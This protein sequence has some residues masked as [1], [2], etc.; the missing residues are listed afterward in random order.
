[1][2]LAG[3]TAVITGGAGGIGRAA[4]RLFAE[5][6]ASVLIAD[7]SEESLA[8]A[9]DEIGSNQVSYWSPT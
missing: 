4:A 7:L 5:E 2:R 8:A 9:V 6:G 3:K 1:M